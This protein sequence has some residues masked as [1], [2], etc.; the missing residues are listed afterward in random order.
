[1]TSV[2]KTSALSSS[3]LMRPRKIEFER[4][5]A[6]K[7][8]LCAAEARIVESSLQGEAIAVVALLG[9]RERFDGVGRRRRLAVIR[10]AGAGA[11]SPGFGGSRSRLGGLRILRRTLCRCGLLGGRRRGIRRGTRRRALGH[12][13]TASAHFCLRFFTDAHDADDSL[14][15]L[16]RPDA[17][18]EGIDAIE[19]GFQLGPE[20]VVL[21]TA[22]IACSSA[23]QS[24]RGLQRRNRG[25]SHNGRLEKAHF[26][27]RKQR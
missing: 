1:M 7:I 25:Y 13:Q 5:E 21:T 9:A 18:F 16:D 3:M 20:F 10:G 2:V 8:E 11:G 14:A 15:L 22:A 17:P 4:E 19:R 12:S 24:L 27:P 26:L 6:A 23:G